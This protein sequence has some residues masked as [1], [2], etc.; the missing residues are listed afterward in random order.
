MKPLNLIS[1]LQNNLWAVR[2]KVTDMFEAALGGMSESVFSI[3]SRDAEKISLSV[4]D[5][6]A[7]V[8]VKGALAKDYGWTG[9][10]SGF[11]SGYLGI[12]EMV[13]KALSEP[14]AKAI[15]LAVDSPGGTVDGCKELADFLARAGK[16]KPLYAYADG[17]MTSAAYWI[18]ATAKEIAAPQTA[19]IGSIGVRTLHV[20]W[21]EWNKK[22]GVSVTHLSAGEYKAMGNADEP[23]SEKAAAYIQ[24]SLERAYDIFVNAV[25]ENRGLDPRQVK[26]TKARVFFA[27]EARSLGLID[28]IEENIDTFFQHI[29]TK[30]GIHM[31]LAT[32]KAQ[33]PDLYNQVRAEGAAEAKAESEVAVKAATTAQTENILSL[34]KAVV[35]E[36]AHAKLAGL[37]AAGIT[38]DQAQALKT[39]FAGKP[40]TGEETDVSQRQEILSALQ[41]VH[42]QGVPP[43]KAAAEQENPLLADAAKRAGKEG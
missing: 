34:A 43:G 41:Q 5:G 18:G 22:F 27:E 30:E 10:F 24:E 13:E 37:I 19:D 4:R 8:P 3:N 26:E 36:E 23:L 12:R 38:A 32:L 28:R 15:L 2:K 39:V 9:F 40:A 31:D 6:I 42:S 17:Q 20:D 11:H 1:I 14:A 35:G 21:S 25:A 33:H 7:I 16:E 29:Q